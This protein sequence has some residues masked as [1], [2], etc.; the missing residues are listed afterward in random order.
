VTHPI[1]LSRVCK[2]T[3]LALAVLITGCVATPTTPIRTPS[4]AEVTGETASKLVDEA[5]DALVALYPPA[6]TEVNLWNAAPAPSD[7]GTA[8]GALLSREL[9]HAGY[10]MVVSPSV[11]A[12]RSTAGAIDLAYVVDQPAPGLYR[13][14]LT[15]GGQTLT[16][17]FVAKG[18]EVM[19]AGA[20]TRRM[21]D[22][23]PPPQAFAPNKTWRQQ[24]LQEPAEALVAAPAVPSARAGAGKE[25]IASSNAPQGTPAAAVEAS[26]QP[27]SAAQTSSAASQAAAELAAVK[28]RMDALAGELER[29][30]ATAHS[31]PAAAP[32]TPSTPQGEMNQPASSVATAPGAASKPPSE[33]SA[34]EI[35]TWDIANTSLR[36]TLQ[37][38][39]SRSGVKLQWDSQADVDMGAAMRGTTFK[40]SLK[41]AI[42]ALAQ[43]L[44]DVGS[45]PI[46]IRF[47]DKG[48]VLK[49]YDLEAS[50]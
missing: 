12:S 42:G 47:T 45:S 13:M 35:D 17:A 9:R 48:A 38:W 22:G 20:W 21:P 16:R 5:M 31:V 49:V 50:S 23:S 8:F 11:D 10:A 34:Q 4:F 26:A 14:Q 30:K 40:G 18:A 41:E 24:R 32:S 2:A 44:G 27:V 29:V 33:A 7:A 25:A 19:P 36:E 15:Y 39:T 37:R 1:P 3:A 6:S 46:G 43:R 28:A